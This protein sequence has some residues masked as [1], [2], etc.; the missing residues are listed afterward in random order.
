MRRLLWKGRGE[1]GG[2]RGGSKGLG[3]AVVCSLDGGLGPVRWILATR[4][5]TERLMMDDE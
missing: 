4:R 5:A 1:G 2:G 3:I